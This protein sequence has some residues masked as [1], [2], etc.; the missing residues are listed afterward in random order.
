[1]ADGLDVF[2]DDAAYVGRGVFSGGPRVLGWSWVK[3][4]Q[5]LIHYGQQHD[6]L[7]TVGLC[8]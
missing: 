1:M 4:A 6:T 7:E 2:Q 5:G 8:E 3:R